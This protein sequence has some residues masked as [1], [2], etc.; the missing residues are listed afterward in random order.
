MSIALDVPYSQMLQKAGYKDLAEGQL[1]KELFRDIDAGS[2]NSILEILTDDIEDDEMHQTI[3]LL[4]TNFKAIFVLIQ[5]NNLSSREMKELYLNFNDLLLE[6]K[7][8]LSSIVNANQEWTSLKESLKNI[9]D[10]SIIEELKKIYTKH[11]TDRYIN[12]LNKR[13]LQSVNCFL[14]D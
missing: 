2:T 1:L 12:S 13:V 14:E 3:E 11:K 10:D 6:Y 7:S 5:N 4:Y 9:F 8:L